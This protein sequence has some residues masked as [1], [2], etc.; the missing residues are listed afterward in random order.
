MIKW[1]FEQVHYHDEKIMKLLKIVRVII[2]EQLLLVYVVEKISDGENLECFLRRNFH[3]I[4]C[5]Q[6]AFLWYHNKYFT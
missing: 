3:L 4:D 1:I 6:F 5:D 2:V